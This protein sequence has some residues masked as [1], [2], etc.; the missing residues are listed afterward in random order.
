MELL[1]LSPALTV[2]AG[3]V[4]LTYLYIANWSP[5]SSVLVTPL[6]QLGFLNINF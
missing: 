3:F 4:P 6:P 2:D 1:N 5:P